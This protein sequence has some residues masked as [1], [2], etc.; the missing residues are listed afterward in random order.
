MS[1]ALK[2]GDKVWIV[3]GGVSHQGEVRRL[4]GS[5]VYLAVELGGTICV[6]LWPAALISRSPMVLAV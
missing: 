4:F 2:V 5:Q 3:Y 6:F 1:A